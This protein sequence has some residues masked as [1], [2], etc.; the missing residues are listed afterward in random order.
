MPGWLP[1]RP[2]GRTRCA[3]VCTLVLEVGPQNIRINSV[4][5][6]IIDTP[7]GSDALTTEEAALPFRKHTPLGHIGQP[8]EVADDVA[9]YCIVR[10]PGFVIGQCLLVDGGFPPAGLRPWYRGLAALAP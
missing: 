3:L 9:C 4:S 10:R 6:S 7:M 2:V 8:E 5:P 1:A